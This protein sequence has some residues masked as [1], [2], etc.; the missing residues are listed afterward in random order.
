MA[1]KTRFVVWN[2]EFCN[3]VKNVSIRLKIGTCHRDKAYIL[4]HKDPPKALSGS[5]V[6]PFLVCIIKTRLFC[7]VFYLQ[8]GK[9]Q[10]TD[11]VESCC[12]GEKNPLYVCSYLSSK[13]WKPVFLGLLLNAHISKSIATRT[14]FGW[15]LEIKTHSGHSTGGVPIS[16]LG[17]LCQDLGLWKYVWLVCHVVNRSK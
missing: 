5:W 10:F 17:A 6:M 4:S 8:L 2:L 3:S 16:N 9:T 1:A 7:E 14:I 11:K 15:F 13:G 12:E